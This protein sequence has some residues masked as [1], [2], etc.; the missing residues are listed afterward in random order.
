MNVAVFAYSRRGCETAR[1][2]LAC[3]PDAICRAYT[4]ERFLTESFLPLQK[5]SQPFYGGLFA[6][7]DA[8]IFVGSC[9]IA[10][11]EIAPH[12]KNKTA[13]PAVLCLDERAGFVIPLLSGHIGGANAL[14]A[15]LAAQ[16]GAVPVITTAT[17]VNRRFSVDA[18]AAEQG[19]AISD[20][21]TAK[22]VSGV[23]CSKKALTAPRRKDL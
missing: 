19:F 5:P 2:V 17:D 14:A 7:A 16:L 6:W 13:D 3:F 8:M 21:K 20:M 23:S 10:V 15:H 22:A 4:M 18:W 1:R 9:G 12:V 11:R